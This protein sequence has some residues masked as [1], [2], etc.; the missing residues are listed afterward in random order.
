M[1]GVFLFAVALCLAASA[2]ASRAD[3][4]RIYAAGS[5]IAPLKRAIKAAGLDASQVADPVFGP[6]GGLRERIEKG[7]AAD[8]FLSADMGHPQTL[9]KSRPQTLVMPFARNTLCLLSHQSL[10]LTQANALNTMLDPKVRLATSTP[11]SDPGGDY[12]FAVFKRAE[13]IRPGAEAALSQKALQLMGGP[14]AMTPLAGHS[15]PASI[16]LA[17]KADILVN[18]CSGQGDVMR[19]VTG[20][21][22][23]RLPPAI[24]VVA[25]YGLAVLTDNPAA[26]RLALF[27]LSDRGQAIIAGNGLV[28]VLGGAP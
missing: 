12:T 23:I 3:P 7:E 26:A 11:L 17:D 16:F 13:A 10:G 5:L 20:L 4:A 28:P 21:A 14:A 27:L 1:R 18:Y 22:S 15:I 8:L 19:D 25:T 9:A 24:D 2:S 6:S